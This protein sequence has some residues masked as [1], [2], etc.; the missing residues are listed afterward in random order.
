MRG[1]IDYTTQYYFKNGQIDHRQLIINTVVGGG[2]G[3]QNMAKIA[4]AN[5]LLNT[6]NNFDTSS[7]N[8]RP[9]EDAVMNSVKIITGAMGNA[10][11]VG[12][13][14]IFT[15]GIMPSLYMNGTDAYFGNANYK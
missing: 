7:Y 4:A 2:S 1:V 11:G 6:A 3:Y 9:S 5:L 10:V 13:G 8:G 12:G 14:N 15:G